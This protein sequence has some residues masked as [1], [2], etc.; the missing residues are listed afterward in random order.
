MMA[1]VCERQKE[2]PQAV[3]QAEYLTDQGTVLRTIFVYAADNMDEVLSKAW[4]E[5]AKSARIYK[6][7]TERQR[8]LKPTTT[9]GVW[10]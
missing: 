7:K 10:K 4:R 2:L 8:D 6:V 3:I 5:N 1:R 9:E